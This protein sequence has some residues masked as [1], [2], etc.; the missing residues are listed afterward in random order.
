MANGSFGLI[1]A[2]D[3]KHILKYPLL[4]AP[5]VTPG[6]GVLAID[7][8]A[9]YNKD[10]LVQENDGVFS[11]RESAL[12]T[13]VL[14]GH[15]ICLEPNAPK[16]SNGWWMYY[17]QGQEGA[18]VGFSCSRLMSL[19]NRKRYLGH[20]LYKRAQLI[21]EFPGEGYEGTSLRAGMDVLRKEGPFIRGGDQVVAQG[22]AANR[23]ATS[24]EQVLQWLGTPGL[25]YVTLLNS[26]GKGYPHR[27]RLPIGI[28]THELGEGAAE[29]SFA[30]DK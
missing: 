1:K 23:W 8:R 13:P 18:C 11:I 29:V 16:D 12:D 28:L 9:G 10:N 2:T 19:Y 30:T 5:T 14:G 17:N 15:A 4:G 22:I 26:W 25:G 20:E 24:G 3:Q 6:P 7:W 21:D 27:V